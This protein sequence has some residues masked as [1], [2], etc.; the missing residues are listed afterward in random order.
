MKELKKTL[1]L[2]NM[3]IL[4]TVIFLESYIFVNVIFQ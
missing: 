4:N 1:N 2:Q 3:K